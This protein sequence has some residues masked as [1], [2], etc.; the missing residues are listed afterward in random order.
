MVW[1][2]YIYEASTGFE[3]EVSDDDDF[4]DNTPLNIED[5]E[6]EYSDEL[7]YMWNTIRTLL[8]DAGLEHTGEFCDFVEFCYIEHDPYKER[9]EGEYANELFYIWRNLRRIVDDNN[10]HE[11]MMRGA[12]FYHFL[13]FTKKYMCV[14]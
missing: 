13:E 4:N 5:W 8:Y 2:Q 6:V 1:S 3:N 14:Y 11:E 10:L 7:R 9:S 12:T